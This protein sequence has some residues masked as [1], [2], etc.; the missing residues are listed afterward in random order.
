[1]VTAVV[2]EGVAIALLAVLVLGLLRSHALI[3]KA[4]H[5]LG[6]GLELERPVGGAGR[7]RSGPV[8]I[9]IEPG[10]VRAER[11][12]SAPATAVDVVGHALDGSPRTVVV[13]EGGTR[14]LLAFLTTGCSVCATYWD[15]F[16]SP[17]DVPGGATL[18]A[19]V[20]GDAEE[21]PS[22]LR[23]LA[24]AGLDLVRSDRAWVDYDVPG[25]P[26][27]VLVDGGAIVGEG[28]ASTWPQARDLLG[29]AVDEATL[30][31][32][33]HDDGTGSAG[34]LD[35]GAR[36]DRNRMDSELR[37]AGITP[38]HPS[39]YPE[40]AGPAGPAVADERPDPDGDGDRRA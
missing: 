22:T 28:S 14:T 11:P 7:D 23:R 15:A 26:Y 9:D 5:E 27:F 12:A 17:V 25:S 40:P 33:G 29:Q 21:S 6:A 2:A 19:V 39:L 31:R 37:A 24:P 38:G 34:V 20:K 35:R 1:M 8:H 36:D 10:V 32:R 4:L 18:V 30:V 16:A 13:T 3:L